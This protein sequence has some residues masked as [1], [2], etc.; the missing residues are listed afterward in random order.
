MIVI[1]TFLLQNN[2]YGFV[3][4]IRVY[5]LCALIVPFIGKLDFSKTRTILGVV[6]VYV[7]YELCCQYEIGIYAKVIGQTVFYVIP[8]GI[9]LLLGFCYRDFSKKVRLLV[10]V[11]FTASF[12]I[13]E[14]VYFMKFGEFCF[15][16]PY[17]YPP[18]CIYIIHALM[19][20]SLLMLLENVFV[21]IGKNAFIVFVSRS[22]LW[23]YLWHIAF[24]ALV[25]NFFTSSFWGVK[26]LIVTSLSVFVVFLQNKLIDSIEEKNKLPFLKIFRG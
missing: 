3:W 24:L 5:L 2:S 1:K 22:S 18:R 8:F 16:Q 17:K 6:I 12:A 13:I 19:Y 10:A 4:I 9:V 14:F 20:I 23:I 26:F 7:L 15:V 11:L 21:K 25:D